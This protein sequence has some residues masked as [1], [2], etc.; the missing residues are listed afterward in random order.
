MAFNNTFI[1]SEPAIGAPAAS[2]GSNMFVVHNAA[3]VADTKWNEPN[4]LVAAY[5]DGVGGQGTNS[6]EIVVP[7]AG[8][9]LELFICQDDA[10]SLGDHTIL[11][12]VYG[13]VPIKEGVSGTDRKW[14]SDVSSTTFGD[15]TDGCLWVPLQNMEATWVAKD[16]AAENSE[17]CETVQLQTDGTLAPIKYDVSGK[18]WY[19]FKRTSVY[20]A[21]CTSVVVSVQAADSL[22]ANSMILGRFVG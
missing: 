1:K 10:G 19:M 15:P 21:G 13:K 8:L 17:Q 7:D 11:C 16:N 12:G 2:W 3:S 14:P 20:L 4:T 6:Q 22:P 9:N 18:V 5:T